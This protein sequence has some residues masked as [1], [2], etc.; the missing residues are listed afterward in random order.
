MQIMNIPRKYDS[1]PHAIKVIYRQEGLP[2]FFRGYTTTSVLIPMNYLVY[3]NLY[4]RFKRMVQRQTKQ[5]DTFICFALP[6][7]LSGFCTNL[8]LSPFWVRFRA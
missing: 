2:G 8:W 4:E 7:V 5:K 6:S 1:L 3:F